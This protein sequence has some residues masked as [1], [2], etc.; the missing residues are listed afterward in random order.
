M[1]TRSLSKTAH[2]WH[3]LRVLRLALCGVTLALIGG[4]T[5]RTV[6]TSDGFGLEPQ[7]A[8]L[9]VA[10]SGDWALLSWQSELGEEY[11][12]LYTDGS[13]HQADWQ[14]L[15]GARG[16]RGT[17]REMR[18]QDQMPRNVTRHYRLMITQSTER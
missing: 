5:T 18:V 6:S 1:A 11:T 9:I 16:I 13:R 8:P 15:E 7:R 10:R 12:I 17:G 14:P 3:S 4:C 2:G